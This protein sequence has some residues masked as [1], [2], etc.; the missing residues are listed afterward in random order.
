MAEAKTIN[1]LLSNGSLS[2]LLMAE[3][4]KWNGVLL[5][6]PRDSYDLLS[7]E[8]AS[9][10][11]GVYLLVSED[12]VYIG[13]ANDLLRRIAEHDKAKDWWEKVVLLTTKDNSLN[14]SDIDYLENKLIK[15][16]TESGTLEMNNIV[17]GNFTKVNRYRE[18]ELEDFLDGALLLLQIIG[19]NVFVKTPKKIKKPV[20]IQTIPVEAPIA[21][22]EATAAPVS[23][24][25]IFIRD[26]EKLS[27]SMVKVLAAK[28][29]I[30]FK[31]GVMTFASKQ[32][33]TEAF[34]A[35]PNIDFVN[36]NWYLILNDN[37]N[38]K[39]QILMVPAHTF[40]VSYKG[41]GLIARTDKRHQIDLH[42]KEKT[43]KDIRSG[44][45]F[46]QFLIKEIDY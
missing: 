15:K 11:W 27:K 22:V 17:R 29:G 8:D 39:L 13:Q 12:Q 46:A 1:L 5:S 43:L 6:S 4:L 25:E 31:D 2:G 34:W 40:R 19:I 26:E 9:K 24:T 23:I 37:K 38:R 35:N 30:F 7:G 20:V 28:A 18:T 41:D 42:L 44:K 16:A 10:Y 33:K 32:D 21:P 36:H 45:E 3:L 14:R